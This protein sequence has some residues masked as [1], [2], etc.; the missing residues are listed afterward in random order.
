MHSSCSPGSEAHLFDRR[1]TLYFQDVYD[2]VV[3]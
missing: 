3:R 1:V 2:H